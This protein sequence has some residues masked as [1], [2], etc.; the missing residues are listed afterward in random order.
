MASLRAATSRACLALLWYHHSRKPSASGTGE[1]QARTSSGGPWARRP[2]DGQAIGSHAGVWSWIQS[3][4]RR[5]SLRVR[6]STVRNQ[7]PARWMWRRFSK[8]HS[9]ESAT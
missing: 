2:G 8:V 1:G 4:N 6:G 5:S 3:L 7:P 9:F